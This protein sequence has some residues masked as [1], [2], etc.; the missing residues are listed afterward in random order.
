M[1]ERYTTIRT[2]EGH[3]VYDTK[4]ELPIGEAYSHALDAEIDAV[5][6]NRS[7]GIQSSVVALVL[8]ERRKQDEEFNTAG[9]ASGTWLAILTKK[10]GDTAS[11]LL[12]TQPRERELTRELVEVAAVCV[13]WLEDL[14]RSR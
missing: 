5:Q 4:D 13:A 8:A 3:Y 7:V 1:A 11:S 14:E 6:L 2:D 9:L 12:T 10:T